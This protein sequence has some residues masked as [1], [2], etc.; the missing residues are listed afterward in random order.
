MHVR[1]GQF[2]ARATAT[3]S[4]SRPCAATRWSPTGQPSAP[5]PAGMLDAGCPL[6]LNAQVNAVE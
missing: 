1:K 2:G 4:S 6:R 5:N 3:S